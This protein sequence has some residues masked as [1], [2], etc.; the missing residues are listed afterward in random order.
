MTASIERATGEV[1]RGQ[2]PTDK[3]GSGRSSISAEV[4]SGISSLMKEAT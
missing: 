1:L 3:S 2:P 4:L